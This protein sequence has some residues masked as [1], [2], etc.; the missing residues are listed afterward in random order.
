VKY[1]K[2]VV[3]VA[4][5][6]VATL[7][8]T[9]QLA[10]VIS[11]SGHAGSRSFHA[12]FTDASGVLPGQDV[13]L[14]G[15]LVGQVQGVH[16]VHRTEAEIDFT[17]EKGVPVYTDVHVQIRYQDLLG[18]RYLA[19][20]EDPQPRAQLQTGSVIGTNAT[21]PALD[22]TV[23]FDGFK[24]LFQALQPGE[25]NQLSA[26]IVATLQGEGG[27]VAQLLST[28]AQLTTTL[29]DKDAVIGSVI[30]NL[31]TVLGT[32]DARDS[33]LNQLI[34]AFQG[35]MS[36]LATD[37]QTIDGALPKVTDLI[38]A[39]NGLLTDAR[40]NLKSD[41]TALDSLLGKVAGTKDTLDQVLQALPAKLNL[42]TRSASYGSWFNFYLCG[43]DVNLSLLGKS[44]NLATPV[45]V[46]AG[47]AGTVC[48]VSGQ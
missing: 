30:T 48:A 40:P 37:S 47:D 39:T 25:V 26:D 29:A 21:T 11:N 4:V 31:N 24:P 22:L 23:L 45:G 28:T 41:I 32:V 44:I 8:L 13:R 27:T 36:G 9:L 7:L 34:D 20:V 12:L 33:A 46:H 3:Y 43:L 42:L 15:V 5:F 2:D 14:A 10:A 6:T 1:W 35:L 16:L 18:G 17:L 38:T 19:L